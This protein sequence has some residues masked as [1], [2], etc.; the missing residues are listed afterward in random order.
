MNYLNP[1]YRLNLLS[2]LRNYGILTEENILE[3]FGEDLLVT[4]RNKKLTSLFVKNGIFH[5]T[6]INDD[7]ETKEIPL[8]LLDINTEQATKIIEFI[9]KK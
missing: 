8:M 3:I 4:K 2:V 1:I 6:Y 5:G 7:N 9:N